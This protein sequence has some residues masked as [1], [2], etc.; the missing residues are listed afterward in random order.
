MLRGVRGA[1]VAEDNTREAILRATEELLK[2]MVEAN[3]IQTED[4]ASIF[5]SVTHDLNAEFPAVAAR[6]LGMSQVPLLCLNEIPV[7][8]S[9]PKCIRLLIHANVDL[10]QNDVR[11]IYLHA[12]AQLR[13]DQAAR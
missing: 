7:A 11:H 9:L 10:A 1:T 13:P 12:A 3:R 5:F 8:G 4:I 6:N 2:K